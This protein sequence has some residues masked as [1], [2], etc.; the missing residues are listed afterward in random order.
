MQRHLIIMRNGKSSFDPSQQT[1]ES[2]LQ[3]PQS[4]VWLDI[5]GDPADALPQLTATFKLSTLVTETITED[6]ERAKF[7]AGSGYFYLVT[8]SLAYDMRTDMADTPKLDIV[9]GRNFV[10]T[11][12]GAPLGWLDTL[13]TACRTGEGKE[14]ILGRGMPY[15]LHAI[16]DAQVDGYFPVL[17]DLDDL[18]DELENTTVRD[19]SNT[20]QARLFRIKRSLA[21]MRRVISPQVELANSLI[22]RTGDLI[23]VEVEPYFADVRDHLVRAFEILDSYRD[24]MSGLLDVYLTTVSNRLNVVMKQLTI[25]ATIFM[26]ITFITGVFG[27]NFGHMPQVEHDAGYDFWLALGLMAI[28]TVGQIWYFRRRGWL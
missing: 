14:N 16:L 17:D 9:F 7:V 10:V 13:R 5:E 2:A 3:D 19:T 6:H 1:L 21:L 8:H 11:A 12:H 27:Q 15:L 28:I 4:L 25:I 26:P 24:L 22:M 18:I 23:P 20:V